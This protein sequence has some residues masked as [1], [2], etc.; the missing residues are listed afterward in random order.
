MWVVP[1]LLR[2]WVRIVVCVVVALVLATIFAAARLH[3]HDSD[4]GLVG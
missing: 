4:Q 3:G 1:E 2:L